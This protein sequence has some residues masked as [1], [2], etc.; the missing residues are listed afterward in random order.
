[1]MC[2]CFKEKKLFPFSWVNPKTKLYHLVLSY[3]ETGSFLFM[4][5]GGET[6]ALWEQEKTCYKRYI[7]TCL[8]LE[9][10]LPQAIRFSPA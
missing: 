5:Q 1:M 8:Y 2:F 7:P 3:G 9:T 10:T 4:Y 6:S